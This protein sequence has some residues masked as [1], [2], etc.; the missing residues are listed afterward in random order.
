MKIAIAVNQKS[1]AL[2]F[3]CADQL[4]IVEVEPDESTSNAVEV[5]E[6]R[7][8]H[9]L[10]RAVEAAELPV[11][12]VVC[13]GID[14]ASYWILEASGKKVIA[15]Q[16][17]QWEEVLEETITKI[18]QENLFYC[19]PVISPKTNRNEVQKGMKIAVTSTG[20]HL[21]TSVDPHFGR[22]RWLIIYDTENGTY[23]A[24]D[25]IKNLNALQ[26]AGI[27][28]ATLVVQ[29]EAQLVLTGNCGPKAAQVLQKAG[30]RV[31]TGI[32]GTV[33]EA[34]EQINLKK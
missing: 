6:F 20:Q 8:L 14:R 15:W 24:I 31:I 3:D 32:S 9:P 2:R 7:S 18:K 10:A 26:G 34:I 23:E 5:Q 27:Q 4:V 33:K 28:T 1:I 22:A 16:E 11:E 13:G 30:V 25:N 19:S 17:G 12:I 21:D 29:K